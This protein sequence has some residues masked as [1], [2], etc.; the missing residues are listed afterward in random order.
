MLTTPSRS[1]ISPPPPD[2]HLFTDIEVY[3]ASQDFLV[4]QTPS[5]ALLYCLNNAVP[6]S[7][8]YPYLQTRDQRVS[9]NALHSFL[10]ELMTYTEDGIG[11]PEHS[12][13][14]SRIAL[15]CGV[16]LGFSAGELC[17][18]YWGGALHDIGKLAL[19]QR[20]LAKTTSLNHSEW[21]QVQQHPAWGYKV[22]N[23]VLQSEATAE[24]ALTHHEHWDGGGYP[25]GLTKEAIPLNGRIIAIA[26][27]FDAITSKRRYRR[28][29]AKGAALEIIRS[30]AGQQFD[31]KL[32][33]FF[34]DGDV[35]FR[36]DAG[37]GLPD[38]G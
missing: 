15:R 20:I 35:L 34:L 28:A 5:V 22:I 6:T 7:Y 25:D 12:Q 37:T 17:Q 33:K 16:A 18:L 26:D 4:Q 8:L 19:D 11:M 21:Q 14:V 23:E 13:R 31:P 27:T 3:P 24:I 38:V 30:E 36:S 10:E 32:V 9:W 29:F 2:A 1:L